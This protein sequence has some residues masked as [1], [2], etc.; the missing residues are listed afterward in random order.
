[1]VDEMTHIREAHMHETQRN[2][3]TRFFRVASHML[4]ISAI[5]T[6]VASQMIV[7][8]RILTSDVVIM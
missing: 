3:T 7:V 2:T 4:A 6:E 8:C 1:M 5:K